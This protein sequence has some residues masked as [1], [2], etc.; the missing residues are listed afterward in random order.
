MQPPTE[1]WDDGVIEYVEGDGSDPA[2]HRQGGVTATVESREWVNN[3]F[4]LSAR[5]APQTWSQ[6]PISP[7]G[8]QGAAPKPGVSGWRATPTEQ[9]HPWVITTRGMVTAEAKKR[10][11][12]SI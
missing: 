5:H 1:R 11:G 8:T 12:R 4:G 2:G 7:A 10:G 9:A 6:P 3:G